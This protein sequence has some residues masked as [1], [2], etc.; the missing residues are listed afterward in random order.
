MPYQQYTN[1]LF[2]DVSS[3]GFSAKYPEFG[4]LR[5]IG[6]WI[7][8]DNRKRIICDIIMYPARE[9]VAVYFSQVSGI[10]HILVINSITNI[11]H[12][13]LTDQF[14]ILSGEDLSEI[15]D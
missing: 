5:H 10:I 1:I 8:C 14:T 11:R 13:Q 7:F 6:F 15:Y 9:L 12:T 3:I 2:C 4:F